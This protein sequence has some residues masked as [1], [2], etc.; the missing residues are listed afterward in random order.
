[1]TGAG[2]SETVPGNIVRDIYR[3]WLW[4][5]EAK[6]LVEERPSWDL[7]AVHYAVYGA[8]GFLEETQGVRLDVD[9]ERGCRWLDEAAA[10]VHTRV[11]CI[12][13]RGPAFA[14][15]TKRAAGSC[16]SCSL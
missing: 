9:A 14:H 10:P 6:Q 16:T 11:E 13:A 5:V 1:M 7:I 3:D 15:Q 8:D 12:A 4:N 2:L